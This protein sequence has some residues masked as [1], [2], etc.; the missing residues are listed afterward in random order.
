MDKRTLVYAT[1]YLTNVLINFDHGII[2]AC[3][4]EMKKDL[5]IDDIQVA[6]LTFQAR[7]AR[8]RSLCGPC[9][10]LCSRL[11]DLFTTSHKN[12]RGNE[13]HWLRTKFVHVYNYPKLLSSTRLQVLRWVFPSK[14]T[15]SLDLPGRLLSSVD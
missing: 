6:I 3:T 13:H 11:G 2:P 9:N 1:N 12:H 10:R 4:S 14:S 8:I 7:D 15:L 5:A